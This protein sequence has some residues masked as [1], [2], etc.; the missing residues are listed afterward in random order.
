MIAGVQQCGL[1]VICTSLTF[2]DHQHAR[3]SNLIGTL[4]M[5]LLRLLRRPVDVTVLIT[6]DG[7]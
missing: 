6:W 7:S 1:N 3:F 4:D 5:N 2:L